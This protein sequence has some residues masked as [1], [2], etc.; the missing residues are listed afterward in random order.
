MENLKE[1]GEDKMGEAIALK[2]VERMP[3]RAK[4]A[5]LAWRV[6]SDK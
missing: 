5:E 3:A 2:I 1:G 4:C 6:F